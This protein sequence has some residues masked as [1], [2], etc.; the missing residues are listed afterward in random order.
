MKL[1]RLWCG[2]VAVPIG[3]LAGV[4]AAVVET[5]LT[6]IYRPRTFWSV[7]LLAGG[8]VYALAD[9]LGVLS[10]PYTP[11]PLDLRG[12]PN[13]KDADSPERFTHT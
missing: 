11:P 7:L 5:R 1:T 10:A 3:V 8:S 4:V 6:G 9:W 13:V 12:G 2:V